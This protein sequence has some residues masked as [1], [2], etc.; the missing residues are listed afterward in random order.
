M[1]ECHASISSLLCRADL[2]LCFLRAEK[3]F[4]PIDYLLPQQSCQPLRRQLKVA[5]LMLVHGSGQSN[6]GAN[7]KLCDSLML[8]TYLVDSYNFS[9]KIKKKRKSQN[10]CT[11][12][13]RD[14]TKKNALV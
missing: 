6:T 1:S 2:L 3:P 8:H 5:A 4:F 14:W 10:S 12:W 11:F 7:C 13:P 9:V